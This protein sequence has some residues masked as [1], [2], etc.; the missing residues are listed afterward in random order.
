MSQIF[1]SHVEE[2]ASIAFEIALRLEEVGYSSWLSEF[3][4]PAGGDYPTEVAKAITHCA[5]F[6]ILIS[7][8]SL[9]SGQVY[10]ELLQAF[11]DNKYLLP[12]LHDITD[13]K[14]KKLK[15]NWRY[16]FK[17]ANSIELLPEEVA[18]TL[19][20]IIGGLEATGTYPGH[21]C[22]QDRI[23]NIRK[24]LC[25]LRRPRPKPAVPTSNFESGPSELREAVDFLSMAHQL[26]RPPDTPSRVAAILSKVVKWFKVKKLT[27]GR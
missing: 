6:L 9:E 10:T 13:E 14:Y 17:G 25:K 24:E 16:C 18:S 11:E 3:D 19:N 22:D 4:V 23:E 2:D 12:V 15:P 27:R 1:I 8:Y 7:P 5:G 20:R 21:K 26:L